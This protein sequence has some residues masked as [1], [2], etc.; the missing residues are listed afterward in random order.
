[1]NT[2]HAKATCLI[3]TARVLVQEYAIPRGFLFNFVTCANYTTEIYAWLGFNIATQTLPGYA[4]MSAGA[5]QMA[6]WAAGKHRR[7]RKVRRQLEA[8]WMDDSSCN[9]CNIT[10]GYMRSAGYV[11][12]S[13]RVA[14][15]AYTM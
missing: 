6:A 1:M 14:E 2:L 13:A 5:L 4:F 10:H 7:L 12:F 3:E 8:W 11:H 9:I 15:D